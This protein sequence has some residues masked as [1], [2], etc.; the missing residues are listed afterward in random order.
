[1]ND[2]D[3]Y[4]VFT[5]E[6]ADVDGESVQVRV[7]WGLVGGHVQMVGMDI[8]RF[9]S[10]VEGPATRAILQSDAHLLGGQ[11]SESVLKGLPFADLAERS[12]HK[13]LHSTTA[14]P[15]QPAEDEVKAFLPTSL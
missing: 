8:R 7:H 4:M 9:F 12:R 5:T 10:E 13:L 3:R 11:L 6:S 15:R 2:H 1:V 14:A